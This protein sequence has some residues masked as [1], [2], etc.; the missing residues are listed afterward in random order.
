M[1]ASKHPQTE[2]YRPTFYDIL[3]A[4]QVL[5]PE[6][7][8][9]PGSLRLNDIHTDLHLTVSQT[10]PERSPMQSVNLTI[11]DEPFR[12]HEGNWMA[13]VVFDRHVAL[14]HPDLPAGRYKACCYKEIQLADLG[15]LPYLNQHWSQD[16]YSVEYRAEDID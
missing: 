16:R 13:E 12:D 15:I 14:E 4:A 5:Q 8:P 9:F 1:S 2:K 11:T 3:P 7:S 10:S 6:L